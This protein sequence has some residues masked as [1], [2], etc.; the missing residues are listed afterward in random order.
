[1]LAL[2]VIW[3]TAAVALGDATRVKVREGATAL[4]RGNSGRAIVEYTAALTDTTIPNDRRAAILNDRAVAYVRMGKNREAIEDYNQAVELFPEYAAVYNNRGN[5]LLALGMSDEAIK[6]FNRAIVLAPGYAAA[7]NNRAGAL[8]KMGRRNAAIRDYTRSVRLLPS[9]PAPLS[10]RGRAHLSLGRPHA[11]IRDFSRAVGADARFAAGYRNRA[12]AKLEVAHYDEAIEDLSR[13]I[14]FDVSNPEVYLLRGHAYLA[15]SR[16]DAAIIDFTKVVDLTPSSAIGYQARGLSYT[17]AEALELALADLNRAIELDRRSSTAFAYRAFAY[18]RNNQPEIGQQDIATALKLDQKNPEV[19][20]A[21]AEV[22]DAGGNTENALAHLQKALDLRPGFKR[23]LD[24]LLRLGITDPNSADHIVPDTERDGWQIVVKGGRYFA[25]HAR[26]QQ[27]R[28]PL[29]MMGKGK[30]RLL[31]WEVKEPPFRSIGVLRF[32]AGTVEGE[33][34]TEDVEQVAIID[35]RANK[36]VAIEP[37]RQGKKI[38]TWTWQPDGRVKVAS[39]DGIT[40]EFAL[41]SVRQSPLARTRGKRP[42]PGYRPGGPAWTPWGQGIWAQPNH[43]RVGQRRHTN[44]K[45]RKRKKK[46]LFQ[47]LFSN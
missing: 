28:V 12:E 34:G 24:M 3:P 35:L 44:R 7:Y 29:E 6:D 10:G 39:V 17:L 23:A 19:H 25:I 43:R 21:A 18:M 30:P 11:A 31:G 40:D 41:R 14:A 26:H 4:K 9:S 33:I 8:L 16:P 20:W 13:A 5:L 27:L 42:P 1:M 45:K 47:L 15:T 22:S 46:S 37:H 36:I 38:S 32:H 2:L